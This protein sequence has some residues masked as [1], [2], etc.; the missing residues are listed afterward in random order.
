MSYCISKKHETLESFVG[1][2]ADKNLEKRVYTLQS[3][4]AI[5]T[6][7]RSKKER[8]FSRVSRFFALSFHFLSVKTAKNPGFDR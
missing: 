8:R 5:V 7:S 4:T 2:Q 1:S 6:H 3:G